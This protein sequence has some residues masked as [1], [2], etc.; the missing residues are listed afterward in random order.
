[1]NIRHRHL[2]THWFTQAYWNVKWRIK[3]V[4]ANS[5]HSFVYLFVFY[6]ILLPRLIN[7]NRN[8]IDFIFNRKKAAL[9]SLHTHKEKS[10]NIIWTEWFNEDNRRDVCIKHWENEIKMCMWA[11][12]HKCWCC[13]WRWWKMATKRV[14]WKKVNQLFPAGNRKAKNILINLSIK[15]RSML[16]MCFTQ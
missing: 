13:W 14:Y 10:V 5:L 6:W 4:K 1:M 3:C 9:Y 7:L 15:T 12:T 16:N 11:T 2:V 8:A